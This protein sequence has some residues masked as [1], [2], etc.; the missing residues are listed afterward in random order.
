MNRYINRLRVKY[1]MSER[2]FLEGP[3]ERWREF[4]FSFK[5]WGEFIKGYRVLHF[6]GPCVTVFGS[7]R[8]KED[9]FYYQEARKLG[10]RLSDLGFAV[11]TGGGPGIMEAANRGAFENNGKS[12]GCNIQLPFEQKENPYLHKW[13]DFRYFFVRKTLLIKYSYA[14]IIMPG[15]WGTMDE[16]FEALTL[17]QTGKIENFP[18]IIFGTEY[19]KNLCEL[20]DDMVLKG[21][22][23]ASDL[24]HLLITDSVE[25]SI[26]HIKK[27]SIE[28]FGLKKGKRIKPSRILGEWIF[29]NRKAAV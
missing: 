17:I 24:D 25:D 14:F 3:R 16:L 4:I 1:Q 29:R 19:W 7:A 21:A 12:I 6:I 26:L 10:A 27:N 20:I 28:K 15:G 18:V 22:V 13:V 11:M 23:S 5:V 8:F 9:H 2:E